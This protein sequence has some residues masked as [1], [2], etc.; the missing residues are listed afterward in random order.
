VLTH[1]GVQGQSL[2]D[3]V[4]AESI[5]NRIVSNLTH[6]T[7]GKCKVRERVCAGQYAMQAEIDTPRSDLKGASRVRQSLVNLNI[8]LLSDH[9]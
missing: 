5:L 9:N 4:I 1:D 3:A 7:F 6:A 2:H 8:P